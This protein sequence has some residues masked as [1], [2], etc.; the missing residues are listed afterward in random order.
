MEPEF[1][2]LLAAGTGRRV[3]QP[4]EEAA[5]FEDLWR[6]TLVNYNAGPGCLGLSVDETSR[7]G[8]PLDWE[9]LSGNLTPV[10]RGAIEYVNTIS[11]STPSI[12]QN[13]IP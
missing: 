2:E 13:G 11:R 7:L 9:H 5:S 3:Y 6:F 4:A 12:S 10:C 8:E 1:A